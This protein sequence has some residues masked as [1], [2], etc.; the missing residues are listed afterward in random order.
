MLFWTLNEAESIY[1][2]DNDYIILTDIGVK[3]IYNISGQLVWKGLE[4]RI[5]K[6]LF[7]TGLYIISSKSK[8]EKIIL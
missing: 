3:K 2:T 4:Q 5:S 6:K 1:R 7:N 8:F